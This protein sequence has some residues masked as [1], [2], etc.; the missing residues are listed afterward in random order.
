[1]D[2]LSLKDLRVIQ[3]QIGRS[4]RGKND[5]AVRCSYGF[6]QVLKV[7]PLLEGK[8]FPTLYWLTCPFL[9]V[10]IDRLESVGAI[11]RLEESMRQEPGLMEA[12]RTAHHRYQAARHAMLSP[13]E[14]DELRA[15]GMLSALSSRGIGGISDLRGIKC[16]HLHAAHALVEENPIGSIVLDLLQEQECPKKKVICSTLV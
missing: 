6:P 8:P 1:M 14:L 15:S 13:S 11:P 9:S 12:M 4:L 7:H 16:L 10:R 3:A 5:V 2:A